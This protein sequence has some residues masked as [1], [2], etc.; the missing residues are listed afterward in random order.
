MHVKLLP[1]TLP[2]MSRG[3]VPLLIHCWLFC[4]TS[5]QL[6][7]SGP[8]PASISIPAAV[9]PLIVVPKSVSAELPPI[10]ND[11]LP[12]S[13]IPPMADVAE[14]DGCRG[15]GTGRE[16]S[17][18]PAARHRAAPVGRRAPVDARSRAVPCVCRRMSPLGAANYRSGQHDRNGQERKPVASKRRPP[19]ATML[20][21]R[22]VLMMGR[23]SPRF[24]P[25]RLHACGTYFGDYNTTAFNGQAFCRI[26]LC[27]LKRPADRSAGRWRTSHPGALDVCYFAGLSPLW[28]LAS[29]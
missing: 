25:E 17:D 16:E 13:Q 20:C 4:R 19:S 6:I 14:S 28:R 7:V 15:V 23:R 10:V 1:L 21:E 3:F 5:G 12:V 18:V 9:L 8:A 29:G 27:K 2:S 11:P 26:T 24:K 22:I